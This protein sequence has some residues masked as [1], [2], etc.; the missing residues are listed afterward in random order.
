VVYRLWLVI[1]LLL[2]GI[3]APATFAQDDPAEQ[4]RP[5][6]EQWLLTEIGKPGLK[7]VEYNYG[8]TSWPDTSLGCPVEGQTY[9]P[10][11]VHGYNWSFFYDNFVRYEVHSSVDAKIIVLCNAVNVAPDVRLTTYR[12]V[13]FTILIPEAWFVTEGT[14]QVLFGPSSQA[15]CDQ[16]GM[17]VTVLGRVAAGVTPDQL[18]ESVL[19]QA[20]V[21]DVPSG[22]AT[23]G[24]FGRTTTYTVP[25]DTLTQQRRLSAFV[26]YGSAYQVE[27]W[28]P[29][30]QANQWDQLFLNMLSQFG[31]ADAVAGP[32][33][34]PA[35]DAGTGPPQAA[36]PDLA[37][38]PALPLAHIFLGDVFLGALNDIPGRSITV[39]PTAERRYL[40]FAPDGLHLSFI[41]ATDGELRVLDVAGGQS[42]RKIAEGVDPG[43]PPSWN[44]NSQEIAY[45]AAASSA[46]AYEIRA[47][48]FNGGESRLLGNFTLDTCP[49]NSQDPADK[50]YFIET[51]SNGHTPVLVWLSD[52]QFLIST[53]C[54][55][56]IGLLNPADG[57][58]TP[59][60]DDLIDGTPAPDRKR[61]VARTASGLAVLDFQTWQRTNLGVGAGVGQIA[62][63]TDGQTVYFSVETRVESVPVEDVNE[64]MA[65]DVFGTWPVEIAVY[66]VSLASVNLTTKQETILWQGQ[67]RGVG[68]ITPA[69]DGSGVLFSLIG[70]GLPL[71]EVFRAGADPVAVESTQP[72][73]A[74][75]WLANGSSVAQLMAY[76]GQPVF[77]PV[78]VAAP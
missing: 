13:D 73:A 53:Q 78:T 50:P 67:G 11:T 24:V 1:I 20:G 35:P 10:G 28:V 31:P 49:L 62:W 22:R 17:A 41:D 63:G 42:T 40:N 36:A 59:L 19:T 69:P 7:L 29:Q 44:L 12:S 45:V 26:Q 38:L 30:D 3:V 32:T 9:T 61:F 16:P 39:V 57:K 47:V 66:Q 60:G 55:S 34:T 5:V 25:C 8:G 4:V 2:S 33:T 70:S 18:I 14:G 37:E 77:A 43:F 65:A 64:T 15:V 75:Y 48:S 72:A 68:R 58:L 51:G 74:L 71:L 76:A 46:G 54:A 23:V 6:V 56:G 27:Q 52:D 21:Q